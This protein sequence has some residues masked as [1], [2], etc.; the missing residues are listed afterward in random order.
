MKTI[1]A[2]IALAGAT[3]TASAQF[4]YT[5]GT[6]SQDFNTLPSVTGGTNSTITVAGRGPHALT[7]GFTTATGVAGWQGANFDGS[8]T[9]T[10]FRA[11]DGSGS[12]G[13]GRGVVS[14][15]TAGSSER[16]LGTLATSN[17]IN[18]FG[19]VLT[20]NTTGILTQFTLS[21]TGEQWRRGN[22]AAPNSLLFFYGIAAGLQDQTAPA[23]PTTLVAAP[24]LNFVAPNTQA[25]PT[26][27]AIDGNAA[28][29]RTL[30]SATI[31]GLTW[32]PGETLVLQWNGIDQSG[33]D[34]GLAID[35]VSFVAVPAPGALALLGLGGLL[36]GRRR[37]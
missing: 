7:A 18:S 15:G 17:Q 23:V 35:D 20:N 11:Q 6:Y 29:N 28:G 14:F 32:N 1:A 4:S 33:Q 9:S 16:A 8:S 37:R 10:E 36:A 24:I 13:T 34:D 3:A 21:Y 26:E 2:L 19:L 25:S 31:T 5:G 30:V 12:G 27:V 22:V